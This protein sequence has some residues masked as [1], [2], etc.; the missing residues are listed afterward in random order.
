[1]QFMAQRGFARPKNYLIDKMKATNTTQFQNAWEKET[2]NS[3]TKEHKGMTDEKGNV[4]SKVWATRGKSFDIFP[5]PDQNSTPSTWWL[6][7]FAI[8]LF[9]LFTCSFTRQLWLKLSLRYTGNKGKER[10]NNKIRLHR[11]M[12]TRSHSPKI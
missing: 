3:E 2:S 6:V 7:I 5:R 1:M 8:R 12:L 9:F 10:G 11:N 4:A